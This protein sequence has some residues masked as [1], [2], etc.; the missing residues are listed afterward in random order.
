MS[1][2]LKNLPQFLGR[3]GVAFFV[4][5]ALDVALAYLAPSSG[6]RLLVALALYVT[7]LLFAAAHPAQ[8]AA[9]ILASFTQPV[10]RRVSFIAFVAHCTHCD[11]GRD[12]R[13]DHDGT[14]GGLPGQL[15]T[16]PAHGVVAQRG[17]NAGPDAGSQTA[18]HHPRGG[19]LHPQ[20][21]PDRRVADPRKRSLSLSGGFDACAAAL[22]LEGHERAHHERS[23]AAGLT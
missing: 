7:G 2:R 10:D 8:H 19:A 20:S 11:S 23:P 17:A 18:K 22:R 13:M 12:R 16:R 5:L 3:W 14:D 1:P 9:L 6:F 21:F 4:L 15:R